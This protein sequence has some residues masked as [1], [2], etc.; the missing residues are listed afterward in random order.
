MKCVRIGIKLRIAEEGQ[1]MHANW[2]TREDELVYKDARQN[3]GK[4]VIAMGAFIAAARRHAQ[5]YLESTSSVDIEAWFGEYIA[6]YRALVKAEE[7][8]E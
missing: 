6:T 3:G 7:A 4:A 5:L 2:D 8:T 1:A